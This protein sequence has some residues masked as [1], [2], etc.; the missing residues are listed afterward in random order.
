MAAALLLNHEC[1]SLDC[2][3]SHLDGL[4]PL[5]SEAQPWVPGSVKQGRT[6]GRENT[7]L[8]HE[9]AER[10][11]PVVGP[12]PLAMIDKIDAPMIALCILQVSTQIQRMMNNQTTTSVYLTMNALRVSV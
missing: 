10:R 1:A 9:S 2:A 4:A 3:P 11:T 6:C 7:I 8:S 12:Q 5:L